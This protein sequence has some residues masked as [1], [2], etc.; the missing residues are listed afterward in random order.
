MSFL[1]DKNYYV[2]S[3]V[4]SILM[5]ILILLLWQKLPNTLP[6]LLI[7]TWGES[8]LV[9][10]SWIMAIPLLIW[11]EVGINLTLSNYW[12]NKSLVVSKMLAVTSLFLALVL[13]V[14]LWGMLQSF[15]I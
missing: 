2:G 11:I 4:I 15:F 5:L 3:L 1:K 10:K 7:E 14:S 13:S 12:K 6:L 8:R 9:Y